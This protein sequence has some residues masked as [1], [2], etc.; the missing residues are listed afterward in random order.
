MDLIRV[1]QCCL[2]RLNGK[3][4]PNLLIHRQQGSQHLIPWICH[5]HIDAFSARI[6]SGLDH[7][8][9]M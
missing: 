2:Q 5:V 9:L 6:T 7:G 4:F 8:V 1:T 3:G